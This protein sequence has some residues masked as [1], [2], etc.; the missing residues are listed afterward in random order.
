MGTNNFLYN[1]TSRCYAIFSEDEDFDTTEMI[2]EDL[3]YSKEELL[4]VYKKNG[5]FI[6]ENID[7]TSE[8]G[9][10][11][12]GNRNFEGRIIG[13][14]IFYKEI[15]FKDYT[16]CFKKTIDIILR[17]GYYKGACFDYSIET[18]LQVFQPS[19][20]WDYYDIENEKLP[21]GLIQYQLTNY[22]DKFSNASV[23]LEKLF[24]KCSQKLVPICQ[25]NNGE[26]VYS[27]V[28]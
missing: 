2:I 9:W 27:Q 10:E 26:T 3:K 25:F 20:S 22:N 16:Y 15:N 17:N 1:N 5:K 11:E 12:N 14:G 6:L 18:E 7:F 28:A 4:K 23:Y 8:Y 24:S 21:H 19:G 13:R